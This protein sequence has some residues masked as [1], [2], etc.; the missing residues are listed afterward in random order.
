MHRTY[1]MAYIPAALGGLVGA[2]LG[3][4]WGGESKVFAV[5]GAILLGAVCY[6]LW[7]QVEKLISKLLHKGAEK[8]EDAITDAYHKHQDKKNG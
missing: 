6:I 4:N 5:I 3:Y 2:V 1:S 8:V 7:R